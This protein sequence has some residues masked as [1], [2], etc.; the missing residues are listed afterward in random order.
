MEDEAGEDE[1]RGGG[2]EAVAVAVAVAA[3][4]LLRLLV[5]SLLFICSRERR[6][7]LYN[8]WRER[9]KGKRRRRRKGAYLEARDEVVR[10]RDTR[11][12]EQ[13]AIQVVVE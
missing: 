10:E 12:R 13:L 5:A 9:R 7:R 1:G 4:A 8:R 6:E 11:L 3:G 2:G